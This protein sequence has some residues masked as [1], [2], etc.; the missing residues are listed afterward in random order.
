MD[1]NKELT[2]WFSDNGDYT[3]NI[4]YNLTEDSNIIDLGGY[5]GVWAQQMIDK[6][7][8]NIYILEPVP[9]FYEEMVTKFSNNNKVHLMNVGIGVEDKDGFIFMNG[10]GTSSNLSDGESIKVRFNTIDTVLEKWGLNEID[11]IQINI[12]GDEYPLLEH[13]LSTGSINKFKNIQVQFHLGIENDVERRNKIR[14]GLKKNN[15][16]INFDYPFVWESWAK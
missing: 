1:N 14:D 9:D 12:E 10:D 11:L 5:I 7:N 13:M 15:F 2:K 8:P 16:K 3:H 6:Y 4:N